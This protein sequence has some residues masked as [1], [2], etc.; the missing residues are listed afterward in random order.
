MCLREID[1]FYVFEA[2]M[3]IFLCLRRRRRRRRQARSPFAALRIHLQRGGHRQTSASATIQVINLLVTQPMWLGQVW[4]PFCVLV[5]ASAVS[6][7][8][9]RCQ[10][11]AV[12]ISN[13]DDTDTRARARIQ[14][15]IRL[16]TKPM[17]SNVRAYVSFRALQLPPDGPRLFVRKCWSVC[18][19]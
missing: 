16:F 12:S 3:G 8:A 17:S 5:A 15:Q 6:G 18:A 13:E 4:V 11:P 2:S 1:L 19:R 10:P 7:P 14:A 9:V